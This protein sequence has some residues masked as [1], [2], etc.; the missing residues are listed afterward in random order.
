[1]PRSL[2][3]SFLLALG[4][5]LVAEAVVR[6]FFVRNMSGRFEYGYHPTAGFEEASGGTLNLVRAGGRR[7]RPQSLTVQ[8]A[9][10]TFRIFVIG[11]SV[12]RGPSL[13]RAYPWLVG[14]ALRERGMNAE[15]FNLGVAG[16]GAHRNRIVV[17]KALDYEPHLI[18]LHVNF[19]NE[20]EDEREYRR[21]REFAGWHPKSWLMK[22]LVIRRLYEAKTEKVFW[23]W[24]P[25]SV[26]N[27][28]A[29]NDADAEL[30]AHQDEATQRRWDERVRAHTA[31]SVAACRR[32]GVPVLL[33][34]Q[35]KFTRDADGTARIDDSRV[36]Q[37]VEPLTGEGVRLLSME[38]VLG[39]Q[40]FRELF[41]DSSH[42][43]AEGHRLL[44]EAIVEGL[45]AEA[46]VKPAR[47]R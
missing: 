36:R 7:F 2:T 46:W 21:S 20:F 3:K 45:V 42:L 4:M 5:L 40:D 13:E 39:R 44:A 10:D 18:V 19:S 8:P 33:V 1:M 25:V 27:Q 24:L 22:S 31:E 34:C 28:R 38:E 14:E 37:L 15:S 30:T 9:P 43:R 11:D 32:H 23:E 17:E 35:A 41:S 16:Y 12:P 29:V 26:R 6:V 47:P